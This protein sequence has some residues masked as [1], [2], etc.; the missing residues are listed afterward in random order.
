LA[1]PLLPDPGD[2]YE[3]DHD[4]ERTPRARSPEKPA[5]LPSS[6]ETVV[7]SG[8]WIS[9][10]DEKNDYFQEQIQ[11]A[12][13][14]SGSRQRQEADIQRVLA[15]SKLSAMDESYVRER[16]AL[17]QRRREARGLPAEELSV[18]DALRGERHVRERQQ[19]SD[20]R[21]SS[22]GNKSSGREGN[23]RDRSEARR[24]ER[25]W[26]EVSRSTYIVSRTNSGEGLTEEEG[27]G[28]DIADSGMRRAQEAFEAH[29][30]LRLAD[31]EEALRSSLLNPGAGGDGAGT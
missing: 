15:E 17:R 20:S 5:K 25:S 24:R 7:G 11:Q 28:A 18:T 9:I 31:L 2:E 3:D 29:G 21:S 22:E 19:R 23:F 4:G 14:R 12:E 6:A 13:G 16:L 10:S 26:R 30:E 27:K 8:N 1:A